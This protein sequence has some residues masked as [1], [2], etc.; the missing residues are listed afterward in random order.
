[1]SKGFLCSGFSQGSYL[2]CGKQN[3]LYQ[4]LFQRCFMAHN[5]WFLWYK[6]TMTS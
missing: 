6:T 3:E 4:E 5:D 1:M 2:I